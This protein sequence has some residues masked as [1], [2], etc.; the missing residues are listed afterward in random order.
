M[1]SEK[2]MDCSK[3]RE[4]WRDLYI[5]FNEKSM[6]WYGLFLGNESSLEA[7]WIT[8]KETTWWLTPLSKWFITLVIS[9]HEP[10][11]NPIYNQG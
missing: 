11:K 3:K 8:K 9:G 4:Q 5:D 7:S 6:D 2:S 10:H 1:I